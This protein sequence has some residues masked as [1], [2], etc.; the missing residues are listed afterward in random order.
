MAP[1]VLPVNKR[2]PV[3]ITD[4]PTPTGA[5]KSHRYNGV[6]LA[7]VILIAHPVKIA[8]LYESAGAM[9]FG[10]LKLLLHDEPLWKA[11]GADIWCKASLFNSRRGF[12]QNNSGDTGEYFQLSLEPDLRNGRD[13]G[14]GIIVPVIGARDNDRIIRQIN[15]RSGS[16]SSYQLT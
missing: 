5:H 8:Q 16:E 9:S 11:I 6:P 7:I 4:M 14:V 10:R 1:S 2:V 13:G 15:H 3:N 12:P